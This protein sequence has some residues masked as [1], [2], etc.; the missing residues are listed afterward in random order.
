M[1]YCMI[2]IT[3]PTRQDAFDLGREMVKKKLAAC[4]Q[5]SAVDSIYT[6]KNQVHSDPEFKLVLKTRNSLYNDIESFVVQHHSYEVPQ[7]VKIDIDGGLTGYL[8]WIGQE[9]GPDKI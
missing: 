7:I 5:I 4:A 9:T 3:C 6:W 8:D 1:S 2:V